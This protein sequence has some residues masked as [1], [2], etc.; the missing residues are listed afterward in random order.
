[1]TTTETWTVT[2]TSPDG[3]E[4]IEN[5]TG[6]DVAA[7]GCLHVSGEQNATFAPGAW[8]GVTQRRTETPNRELAEAVVTGPVMLIRQLLEDPRYRGLGVTSHA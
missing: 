1:M 4:T 2:V 8:L 3:F 7:D 5:S 6:W